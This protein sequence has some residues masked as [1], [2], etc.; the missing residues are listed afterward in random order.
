MSTRTK[1]NFV[2]SILVLT[3]LSVAAQTSQPDQEKKT[4]Q[5]DKKVSSTQQET[6]FPFKGQV[7]SDKLN[8]RISP[9][10]GP[11]STIVAIL[12]EG[13]NVIVLAKEN[14]FYQIYTSKGSAGWVFGK[15]MV[16]KGTTAV[17]VAKE[18]PIRIDSRSDSKQ[19]GMLK[20]GDS[21][22]VV[23]EHLGWLK[24]EADGNVKLYAASKYIRNV[25]PASTEDIPTALK[26]TSTSKPTNTTTDQQAKDLMKKAEEMA[27]ALNDHIK[28]KTVEKIDFAP[29]VDL[30]DQAA[31]VAKTASVK[32]LAEDQARAY[33]RANTSWAFFKGQ[34][35]LVNEKLQ[36]LEEI[37][38]RAE[39]EKMD[40]VTFAFTGFIDSTGAFIPDRPGTHKLMTSD[41][42]IVCFLRARGD[43]EKIYDKMCNLWKSFVGVRGTVVRDPVGWKGYSVVLVEEVMPTNENEA[44]TSFGTIQPSAK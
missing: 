26:T 6:K 12:N 22:T 4:D 28:N 7:I 30:Y 41:G 31:K 9:K 8:V 44:I 27:D 20:E 24:I 25:G 11:D 17:V 33:R 2:L 29:I 15:N 1:L 34:F 13:E 5:S 43:D 19:I 3:M 37:R 38:M 16:V 40:K 39:R 23:K 32:K 42:K 35:M 10:T 14:E 36:I 21:V 18:V